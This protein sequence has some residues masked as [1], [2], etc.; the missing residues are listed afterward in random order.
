MVLIALSIFGCIDYLAYRSIFTREVFQPKK[1]LMF[2]DR[3]AVDAR[4]GR[5]WY[6]M[7]DLTWL[8]KTVDARAG[9]Y[10]TVHLTSPDYLVHEYWEFHCAPIK[11]IVGLVKKMK[12]QLWHSLKMKTS[13]DTFVRSFVHFTWW[14]WPLINRISFLVSKYLIKFLILISNLLKLSYHKSIIHSTSK[15]GELISHLSFCPC[16]RLHFWSFPIVHPMKYG[17]G[18]KNKVIK[19]SLRYLLVGQIKSHYSGPISILLKR[20]NNTLLID[21]TPKK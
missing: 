10:G 12:P 7:F 4:V 1:K 18:S 11:T 13:R 20:I 8:R 19:W 3:K 14:K 21:L 5:L 17:I 9:S 6:R 16:N 15:L 2:F